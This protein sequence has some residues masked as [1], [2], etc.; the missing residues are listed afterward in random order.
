M[1]GDA[2]GVTFQWKFNGIDIAG[3]TGDSLILLNVSA[4][5]AGRYS[6]VVTNGLGSIMS[7][8][9][10]LMLD[11]D[12]DGIPD[13]WYYNPVIP[14]PG[15]VA[16][17]RGESDASDSVG[18]HHGTFYNGGAVTTPSVAPGLVGN[19]LSF[20]G[21]VNVH[22][23]YAADLEPAQ[24]T[25]EAWVYPTVENGS[26]QTII[27]RPRGGSNP[28]WAL[29]LVHGNFY[30]W[31]YQGSIGGNYHVPLNQWTHVAATSDGVT[32]SLY[33]N[34][35]LDSQD[36]SGLLK[37]DQPG[38]VT[39][40]DNFQGKIDE[41]TIYNRTLTL[42]Q[43]AAI[44]AANSAGKD[45][46][47]PYFT[48]PSV[49]PLAWV[50]Q[51]YLQ[52]VTTLFGTPPVTFSLRAGVLPPGLIFTSAGL[53][54]GIPSTAGNFSF[55]LRVTDA[56]ANWNFVDQLFTVPVLSRSPTLGFGRLVEG[57]G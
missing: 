20:D 6:V 34:G 7:T 39:L 32:K 1:V 50:G 41:L 28:S 49:F 13:V 30:F 17:W 48:S 23:P 26:V 25:I 36:Q 21:T 16:F 40:G 11:S 46:T 10:T 33:V 38:P 52:Q 35:V 8:P 12:G 44:T 2:S 22:V 3:A 15:M 53:L 29:G 5:N 57:G 24:I 31:N 19:A 18:A 37:Y 54:S 47:R 27:T 42:N 55:T 51:N 9:T 45:L 4:A 43:V 14:A 56:T